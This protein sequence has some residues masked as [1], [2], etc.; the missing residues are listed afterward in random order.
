MKHKANWDRFDLEEKISELL[1]INEDIDTIMYA[2]T[3]SKE[4]LSEDALLNMLIGVKTMHG[5]RWNRMWEAFEV[6]IKNGTI[7][8]P[9]RFCEDE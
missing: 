4:K 3:E 9:E 6:L 1:N 2:Y 5:V 7:N 8:N